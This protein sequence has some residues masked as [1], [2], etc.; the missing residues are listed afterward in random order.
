MEGAGGLAEGS[1]EQHLV[2]EQFVSEQAL[3]AELDELDHEA[4]VMGP[5][6]AAVVRRRRN[7]DDD[8]PSS[9]S[10]SD[11]DNDERA[12]APAVD[13][14]RLCGMSRRTFWIVLGVSAALAVVA[15]A[16]AVTVFVIVPWRRGHQDDTSEYTT[17][18]VSK[19]RFAVGHCP[20]AGY[21]AR[22]VSKRTPAKTAAGIMAVGALGGA[23]TYVWRRMRR[24]P[25]PPK[26][27]H[28]FIPS[29]PIPTS[30]RSPSNPESSQPSPAAPSPAEEPTAAPSWFS[31]DDDDFL[32]EE[33][34]PWKDRVARVI[35]AV[36]PVVKFIGK[37]QPSR[38]AAKF[39]GKN[40]LIP[41]GVLATAR[42]LAMDQS[43]SNVTRIRKVMQWTR[44]R[45]G[46][47]D[48]DAELTASLALLRAIETRNPLHIAV[49]LA[50]N[51]AKRS[52]E[53]FVKR[54]FSAVARA[55][56]IS[57]PTWLALSASI[58][59]ESVWDALSD[60]L[61]SRDPRATPGDIVADLSWNALLRSL[62]LRF[63][64]TM[65]Y[66]AGAALKVCAFSSR[67]FC[68]LLFALLRVS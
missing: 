6:A 30:L 39:V 8:L 61:A 33:G 9:L 34:T 45:L 10:L 67:I 14:R 25:P 37:S 1:L 40:V 55:L 27:T 41:Q 43:V 17:T 2:I 66:G 12:S 21:V 44:R 28:R 36:W 5:P 49:L 7:E 26:R 46:T 24:R 35:N 13:K 63:W 32:P 60:R 31:D 50:L 4:H 19:S 23:L 68:R 53:S 47:N 11:S 58:V 54:P 64:P 16:V 52:V 18:S 29:I 3:S 22:P 57:P 38:R 42:L 48:M 56:E 65:L 62:N 15:A 51:P 59:K 20:D